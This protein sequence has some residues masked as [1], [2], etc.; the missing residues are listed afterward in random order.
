[1]KNELTCFKAYD[2]RG[3]LGEQLNEDI[4]YRIGRAYAQHLNAKN[5]VVGGDARET[6]E[7]LKL[8]L[9]K[10]LQDSGCNVTD[11]GM[12]GTEEIYFATSDLN[13]DGGIVVTASHNPID[14]NGMKLVREESKPISGD[15][16]LNDI[17]DLVQENNFSCAEI[18]GNYTQTSNLDSY[19]E[20]LLTYISPENIRPLKLVVNSGNGAAGHVIDAL[21]EQFRSL[22]VPIEFIK[23]HHQPDHTFPNGIPNPLLPENRADTADAV[24]KHGA[25]MGIAWDGDFD[26]CF[27]FDE[28]GNFIEGYYIVGLLAEAFL[29]KNRNERII[30][31]PRVYWNTEEIITR[32]GG[33]PVMSKTGHAF[34]KER[35]RLEDAVYGGEMSAHHYFRDF[36]YCDSGMIPW[37]LVAELLSLKGIPLSKMVKDRIALYPS[38]G[39]INFKVENAQETIARIENFD[40]Q[41][42]FEI[43]RVDGLDIIFDKWRLNLRS[44]N[45]EPVIRLNVE[46]QSDNDLLQ[47]KLNQLIAIIKE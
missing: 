8:A 14:Y 24:K 26:R 18:K 34:I 12:V 41:E 43:S 20:H 36:A 4:A 29:Q 7:P 44:S 23:I 47:S 21:E 27:L 15:T 25:D 45:T 22:D 40:W 17:K 32:C 13:M 37:L 3:K 5:V 28:N 39:E 2:I 30:Y 19:V 33:T 10:G 6:S 11:I 1:M 38:S 42:N 31:D 46:T 9:A 35:M 16:G